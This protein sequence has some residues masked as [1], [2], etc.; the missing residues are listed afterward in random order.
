MPPKRLPRPAGDAS[1]RTREQRGARTLHTAMSANSAPPVPHVQ[2]VHADAPEAVVDFVA[3]R[4]R[5][6]CARAAPPGH[7]ELAEEVKRALEGAFA[8]LWHVVVGPAFG[9]SVSH[10]NNALL[11]LRAGPTH[12]LCF[13][14]VDAASLLKGRGAA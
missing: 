12:V 1:A 13:D 6:A 4:L 5:E 7:K 8:G 14:S 9:L 2:V 3:A 10:E 11:L